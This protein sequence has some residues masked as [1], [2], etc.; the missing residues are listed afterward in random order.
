MITQVCRS[1]APCYRNVSPAFMDSI[2]KDRVDEALFLEPLLNGFHLGLVPGRCQDIPP[3]DW[4]GCADLVIL[5]PLG[6]FVSM[7]RESR[8]WDPAVS[9]GQVMRFLELVLLVRPMDA[10]EADRLCNEVVR[11]LLNRLN[12]PDDSIVMLLSQL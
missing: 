8:G 1:A 11:S 7:R 10:L 6:E 4:W 9:L 5:D 2:P 3:G 12:A